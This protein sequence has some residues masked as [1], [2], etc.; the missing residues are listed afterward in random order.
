MDREEVDLLQ[1]EP[2]AGTKRSDHAPHRDFGL[3]KMVEKPPCVND[4][5]LTPRKVFLDDVVLP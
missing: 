4:V 1:Q 3:G 5:E 2:P